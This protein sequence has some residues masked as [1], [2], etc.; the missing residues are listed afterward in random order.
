MTREEAARWLFL[1]GHALGE[2]E[3]YWFGSLYDLGRDFEDIVLKHG[4]EE[5][6]K[7]ASVHA[8]DARRFSYGPKCRALCL[9]ARRL[10]REVI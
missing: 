6:A 2:A 1:A 9:F 5:L 8:R 7:L 10:A 4:P 3:R